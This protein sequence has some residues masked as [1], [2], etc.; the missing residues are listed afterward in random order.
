MP[1]SRVQR[2]PQDLVT[3][4]SAHKGAWELKAKPLLPVTHGREGLRVGFVG[5][6]GGLQ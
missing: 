2:P 6:G 1:G 4:L 5:A 3:A